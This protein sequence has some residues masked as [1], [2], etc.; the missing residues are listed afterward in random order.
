MSEYREKL[1]SLGFRAKTPD[2][3]V[4]KDE[5][6]HETVEHFDDLVDVT[7]HAPQVGIK[8]TANELGD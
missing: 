3:K 4:T 5:R 2:P 6:G 1:E 8:A 7:I